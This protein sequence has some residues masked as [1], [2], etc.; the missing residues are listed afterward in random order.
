MTSVVAVIVSFKPDLMRLESL[1]GALESQVARIIVVDN[2]SGDQTVGALRRMASRG[3]I[4][5]VENTSNLGLGAAL[6]Q[7][8]RRAED[9]GAT[10]LLLHD[11][12]S[13]PR[14]HMV[15]HL[16]DALLRLEK[17]GRRVAAV[18]PVWV[19][20][21]HSGSPRFP[22][23]T[24]SGLRAHKHHCQA[25]APDRL[26]KTHML[27][28]SGTFIGVDVRR[29]VGPFDEG[30]FV[31]STDIEWCFRAASFD[32][33]LYGVCKAEMGHQLGDDVRQVGFLRQRAIHSSIR[34]YYMMRNRVLLYR[35]HIAPLSW[36]VWD[37]RH[38][39]GKLV[40]FTVFVPP[41]L[42]NLQ[43]MLWG[44]LDGFRG[45]TGPLPERPRARRPH[46][47]EDRLDAG[48]DA[49]P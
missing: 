46:R 8:C 43:F 26:I 9:L 28:T 45:T 44:L 17:E 30:M 18:G 4:I 42:K 23:V 5:L 19:D 10:H 22:F 41:R 33:E 16:L 6:N 13:L 38:A 36:I 7:G 35:R 37:V 21:R 29:Q 39:F 34:L 40:L 27:I 47:R 3:T 2:A 25:G 24:Y 48:D 12:D 1:L 49:V 11:Q 32:Y 15:Q 20:E 14:P 31:D